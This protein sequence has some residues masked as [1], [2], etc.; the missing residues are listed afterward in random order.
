MGGCE[1]HSAGLT[2]R[3]PGS[4][5]PSGRLIHGKPQPSRLSSLAIIGRRLP[6]SSSFVLARAL[7]GAPAAGAPA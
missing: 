6:A 5:P 7:T 2:H 4:Q 1:T 3:P